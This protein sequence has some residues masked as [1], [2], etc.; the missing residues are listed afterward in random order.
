MRFS[1][2]TFT[3][4]KCTVFTVCE[5]PRVMI[6]LISMPSCFIGKSR[7]V[8]PSCFLPS[9]E[10]RVRQKIQSAMCAMVVQILEPLTT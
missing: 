2:G 7:K 8:M 5:P 1:T 4:V 3:S 6:G 9:E 10:V